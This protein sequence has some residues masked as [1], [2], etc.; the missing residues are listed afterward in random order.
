MEKQWFEFW[1]DSPYYHLL[2]KNRDPEEAFMFVDALVDYLEVPPNSVM[3]DLACGRGRHALQLA[4]RGFFVTGLDISPANVNYAM[5]F[6]NERLDFYQHDMRKPFRT[7]Y[8]HYIFNFF[9]S[10]GYFT[11]DKDHEKTIQNVFKGLKSKGIFVLD[12]MNVALVKKHLIPRERKILDE[13]EFDITRQIDDRYITKSIKINNEGH[14]YEYQEKVR[15]Y[16]K[17]DL[18]LLLH[19]AGFKIIEIFGDHNLAAFNPEYSDRLIYV[20]QKP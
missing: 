2:Y 15:A 20:A 12:F 7:N 10:F 18:S 14:F 11:N 3:L 17:E 19:T 5:D 13:V 1:F 8:Y 9:T 16:T 6:A 4:N